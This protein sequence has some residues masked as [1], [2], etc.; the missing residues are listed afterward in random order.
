MCA[1]AARRW[2]ESWVGTES[3][4]GGLMDLECLVE[5]RLERRWRVR[6]GIFCFRFWM[7]PAGAFGWGGRLRSREEGGSCDGPYC[8]E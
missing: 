5:L 2:G 8:T 7:D 1:A 6:I 3:F 4:R